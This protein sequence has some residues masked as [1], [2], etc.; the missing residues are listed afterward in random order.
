VGLSER[1]AARW[2]RGAVRR[3]WPTVLPQADA[4]QDSR[5]AVRVVR[6]VP[7]RAGAHPMVSDAREEAWDV[8]EWRSAREARAGQQRV[9]ARVAAGELRAASEAGARQPEG[10]SDFRGRAPV[11]GAGEREA[12]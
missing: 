10:E 7:G 9:A 11:A 3:A 8:P 12:C 2:A 1:R 6:K 5:A 4:A